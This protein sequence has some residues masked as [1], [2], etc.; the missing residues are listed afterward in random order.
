[1]KTIKKERVKNIERYLLIYN[2]LRR[3][4]IRF[5]DIAKELKLTKGA[6][7]HFAYGYENSKRFDSWVKDNLGIVL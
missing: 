2:A 7:T 6:I 1:M 4:N 3:K 5:T